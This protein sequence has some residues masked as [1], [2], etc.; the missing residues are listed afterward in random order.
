MLLSVILSFGTAWLHQH[1]TITSVSGD[2]ELSY[3]H[4]MLGVLARLSLLMCPHV[5]ATLAVRLTF[6][7]MYGSR[8]GVHPHPPGLRVCLGSL[9]P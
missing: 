1:V 5:A 3:V 2:L 4:L 7:P 8:I 6:Q 9:E